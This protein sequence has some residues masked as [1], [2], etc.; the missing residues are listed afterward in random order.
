METD[1]VKNR[2]S[3]PGVDTLFALGDHDKISWR[4]NNYL[5][6]AV[7][8]KDDLAFAVTDPSNQIL[9]F[10]LARIVAD[11]PS[12]PFNLANFRLV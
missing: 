1:I 4:K 11:H 6:L 12:E 9:E 3:S 7:G 8:R 2:L 10:E 5:I